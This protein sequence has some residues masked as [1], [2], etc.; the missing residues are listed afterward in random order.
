M[1]I[2][3][4]YILIKIKWHPIHGLFF[5]LVWE[6]KNCESSN[7]VTVAQLSGCLK[8]KPKSIKESIITRMT[9]PRDLK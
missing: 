8:S 5:H 4:I 1:I 7:L 6:E 9:R 3:L 2:T